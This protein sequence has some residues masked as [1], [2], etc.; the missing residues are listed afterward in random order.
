MTRLHRPG[1]PRLLHQSAAEWII[2]YFGR[3][4]RLGCF[5]FDRAIKPG[6]GRSS[7]GQLRAEAPASHSTPHVPSWSH[8]KYGIDSLRYVPSSAVA[9]LASTDTSP[10]TEEFMKVKLQVRDLDLTWEETLV[11]FLADAPKI[12]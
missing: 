4:P 6:R 7:P 11:S 5:H 3:S 8:G 9:D 2:E 1:G 10:S 12:D